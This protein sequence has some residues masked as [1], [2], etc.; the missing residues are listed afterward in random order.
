MVSTD[1]FSFLMPFSCSGVYFRQ[2]KL[3]GPKVWKYILTGLRV[4]KVENRWSNVLTCEG[5]PGGLSHIQ[6]VQVW[7]RVRNGDGVVTMSSLNSPQS[8][9]TRGWSSIAVRDVSRKVTA[10]F[11]E[12]ALTCIWMVL[13]VLATSS[14]GNYCDGYVLS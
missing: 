12:L 9:T 6:Y 1:L 2:K 11:P 7:I 3:V 14:I 8:S 5:P 13:F 10:G 4:K